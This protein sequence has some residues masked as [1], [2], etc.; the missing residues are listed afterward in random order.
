MAKSKG[1]E[2]AKN[3]GILFIGK[4]STQFVSFLLL[5]LYTSRLSKDQYGTLDLY[6]TIASI[7]IPILS[8]QLEQAIFRFFITAEDDEKHIL[9][10]TSTFLLLSSILLS[11][12]YLPVAHFLSFEYTILVLLYYI[13]LLF[14]TVIQQVPR[15]YSDYKT[16]T[17]VAFLSSS[18]SIV[19]SVLFICVFHMNID[20]ILI[21]RIISS[22]FVVAYISIKCKLYTKIR[23]K[24]FKLLSLKQMLRYSVP[25]V[26]NQLGSWIVNYS[27]RLIIVSILGVGING[28]YAVANKFFTLITTTL[29]IYNMAWTESVTKALNDKDKNEYYNK[30]FSLTNI[31][32]CLA[33]SGITSGIGLLFPF[34]IDASFHEA[35]YQIPILVYAA[36]FSGLAANIGSI[37]VAYKMT[38]EISKTTILTAIVNILTHFALIRFIGLYAASVSTFISFV[39]LFYYRLYKLKNV[40]NIK[41]N[42]KELIPS[43]MI[44][45]FVVVSYYYQNKLIQ[46]ISLIITC[47][48]VLYFTL[49]SESMKAQLLAVIRK[50]K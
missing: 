15:G 45:I 30:V 22:G 6:T 28:I 19:F 23:I 16:Y 11:A 31:L 44:A 47:L 49:S 38:R 48:Y 26:F 42:Y 24:Y 5:P 17:L 2:L 40:E 39:V 41:V 9:S 8:L 37:Y 50:K 36:M 3:T 13:T 20:G 25:L 14:S 33:A 18:I 7:L 34:F 29:N 32:F 4:I 43:A 10:S 27:D 35:Y 1:K 46:V 12:I 21:A